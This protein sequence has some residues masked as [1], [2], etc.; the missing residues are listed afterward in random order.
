M[1]KPTRI[2]LISILT[3]IIISI[4]TVI[5]I[6]N[7]NLKPVNSNEQA[8]EIIL[9]IPE[10]YGVSKIAELLEEKNVIKSNFFFKVYSKLNKVNN[11]QAGKYCS[12]RRSQL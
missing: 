9:E 5:I 3:I 4:V 7:N 11:L 10:G 12:N 6:Y 2:I 8:Q 1:K